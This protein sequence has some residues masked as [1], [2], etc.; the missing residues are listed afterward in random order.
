MGQSDALKYETAQQRAGFIKRILDY[1]LDKSYVDKQNE[2]LKNINV[3][4]INILAKKHLPADKMVILV[5]GDKAKTFDKLTKLGYEVIELDTDG[6]PLAKA[7]T[8]TQMNNADGQNSNTNNQ[9]QQNQPQNK[10]VQTLPKPGNE[11]PR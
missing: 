5:V 7:D 2:I 3:E 10:P 9:Q 11:K 8:G 6:N 1:K 4:E